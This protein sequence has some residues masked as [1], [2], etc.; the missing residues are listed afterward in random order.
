M[1]N[2]LYFLLSRYKL[3]EKKDKTN[4]FFIFFKKNIASPKNNHFQVCR[5]I[6]TEK[7]LLKIDRNSS[8]KAELSVYTSC[9]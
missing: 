9:F 6:S 4:Y 2:T 7:K 8:Y 5:I 3:K 1:V